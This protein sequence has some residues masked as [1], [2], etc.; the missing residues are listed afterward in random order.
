MSGIQLLLVVVGWIATGCLTAFI[1]WKWI[2]GPD[3][4]KEHAAS[5][6]IM[7]ATSQLISWGSK[8]PKGYLEGCGEEAKEHALTDL[9]I[10]S[11][12]CGP[13]GTIIFLCGWLKHRFLTDPSLPRQ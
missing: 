3:K 13:I 6:E 10:I 1:R 4:I 5:L 12:F 2:E 11:T 7:S 9:F 8:I